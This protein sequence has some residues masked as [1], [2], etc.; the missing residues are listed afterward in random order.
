MSVNFSVNFS[1]FTCS[2]AQ[3]FILKYIL[4]EYESKGFSVQH[5]CVDIIDKYI[6]IIKTKFWVAI[7]GRDFN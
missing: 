5:V 7:L 2:S 3:P 1:E 4:I 6:D